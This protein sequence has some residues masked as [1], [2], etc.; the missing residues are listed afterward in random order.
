MGGLC[1]AALLDIWCAE[2][3][4]CWDTVG[5]G[6]LFFVTG[7]SFLKAMSYDSWRKAVALGLSNASGVGTH[8]LRKGGALWWKSSGLVPDEVIQAQGGWSSPD[9]MR[10]FYTKFSD[11]QLRRLLLEGALAG[12]NVGLGQTSFGSS[13]HERS[14]PI[15]RRPLT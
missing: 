12:D 7:G 8:S 2:W 6:P 14:V 4:S 15:W 1:P 11:G 3:D 10:A 13:A 9:V 5:D